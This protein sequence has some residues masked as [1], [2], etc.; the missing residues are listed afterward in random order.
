MDIVPIPK[1][2]MSWKGVVIPDG[3]YVPGYPTRRKTIPQEASILRQKI[4]RKREMMMRGMAC[5]EAECWFEGSKEE[6]AQHSLIHYNT[7]VDTK[8]ATEEL[9]QIEKEEEALKKRKMDILC[10]KKHQEDKNSLPTLGGE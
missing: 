10:R 1:V 3:F 6:V 8:D 9:R 7:S 4:E 5:V 2:E